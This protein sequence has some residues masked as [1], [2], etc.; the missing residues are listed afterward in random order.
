MAD[1]IL[2]ESQNRLLG[3]ISTTGSRELEI[4]GAQNRLKVKYDPKTNTTRDARNRS[5]GKGNLL[6]T[7]L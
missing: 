1:Q 2:K 6:T 3:K 4:R 5:V 7:L